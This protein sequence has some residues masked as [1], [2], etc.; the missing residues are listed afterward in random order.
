MILPTKHTNIEQSF[1]GFGGY[2]LKV[3]DSG[4]EVDKLWTQ[5]QKD[6]RDGVY[7]A[8]QSFDNLLLT[9]TFLF[10]IDVICFDNG[11]VKRCV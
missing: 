9:I 5:Y 3:I 4:M 1:L 6:F 10:S 8:I 7:N 11:K 2:I